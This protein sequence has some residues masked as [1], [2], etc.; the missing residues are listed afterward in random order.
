MTIFVLIL[1]DDLQLVRL[2]RHVLC[3]E[4][5][6]LIHCTSIS[7]AKSLVHQFQFELALV[8]LTLG[9]DDNGLDFVR[10][11]RETHP[12]M[13]IMVISGRGAV[14]DRILGIEMGADDY[15]SKPLD[16]REL[17]ARARRLMQRLHHPRQAMSHAL[18]QFSGFT[19]DKCRRTLSWGE[20][21]QIALTSREFDLL[22]CLVESGN[23]V[24]GRDTIASMICGR[25][26]NILDRSVD[27][28][29]SS[30]R[31]K[32]RKVNPREILIKSVRGEGYRFGSVAEP[33]L[34]VRG[35]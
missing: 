1:E 22:V 15:L 30:L 14:L 3:H 9:P 17:T 8:D 31:C 11:A 18:V 23:R 7:H 20:G 25:P 27:V 10:Y 33:M 34:R 13:G 28:M 19:L 26:L 21:T 12:A 16:V 6:E 29:V 35:V 24:I 32:L 5:F 4:G 2:F